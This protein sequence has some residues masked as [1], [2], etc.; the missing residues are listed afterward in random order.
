MSYS[1][2]KPRKE[3]QGDFD[4]KSAYSENLIETMEEYKPISSVDSSDLE[5]LED[6]F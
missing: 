2:I 3:M 1:S 5:D 4:T 6:N